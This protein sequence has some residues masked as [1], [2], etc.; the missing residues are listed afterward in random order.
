MPNWS[1]ALLF[2]SCTLLRNIRVDGVAVSRKPRPPPFAASPRRTCDP[3]IA[4]PSMSF[5]SLNETDDKVLRIG[6]VSEKEMQLA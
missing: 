1:G 3:A 2:Y 5:D 6:H 4:F